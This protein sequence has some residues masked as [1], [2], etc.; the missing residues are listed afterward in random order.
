MNFIVVSFLSDQFGEL[1]EEFSKCVVD[2]GEFCGNVAQFRRRHQSISRSVQEADRF[3]MIS[4]AAYFC[5]QIVSIIFIFYST[6]FYREY[7]ISSDAD[8]AVLYIGWLSM[9]VFGLSLTA[10]QAIILNSMVSIL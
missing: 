1:Y 4:N 3:L 2:Q 7:T 5:C 9:S 6:V 8:F 10:G